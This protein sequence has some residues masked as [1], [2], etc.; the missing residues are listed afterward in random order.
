M[1]KKMSRAFPGSTNI[2][3]KCLEH[4]VFAVVQN[5]L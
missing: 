4:A 1:L 2:I 5:Q 3:L